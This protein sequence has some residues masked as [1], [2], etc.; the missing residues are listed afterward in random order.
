MLLINH[1]LFFTILIINVFLM[2]KRHFLGDK[3]I[4]INFSN[5]IIVIYLIF[6]AS[7]EH[8]EFFLDIAYI[9]VL[10]NILTS[11]GLMYVLKGERGLNEH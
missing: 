5:L 9:Y 3:L 8:Q 7:F 1:L 11:Y 10:C 2:I 4:S 6:L